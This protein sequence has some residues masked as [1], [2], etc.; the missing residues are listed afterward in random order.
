MF[1]GLNFINHI[2]ISINY[3]K[4]T[5]AAS[6]LRTYYTVMYTWYGEYNEYYSDFQ[7]I[8]A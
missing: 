4:F 2:N 1:D 7:E 8:Y 6:S 5:A 3:I